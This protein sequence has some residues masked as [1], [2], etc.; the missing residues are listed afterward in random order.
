MQ[1]HGGIILCE[2]DLRSLFFL[3]LNCRFE[4]C[5]H[6]I[7]CLIHDLP[8]FHCQKT[9]KDFQ[10]VLSHTGSSPWSCVQGKG[11]LGKYY[12]QMNSLI[13]VLPMMLNQGQGHHY[14]FYTQDL[15]AAQEL[16]TK[17]FHQN[18]NKSSENAQEKS[19]I[20]NYNIHIH[21]HLYL[22]SSSLHWI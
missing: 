14:H 12:P 7:E 3:K 16:S 5:K 9:P 11:W 10:T 18:V 8:V 13:L 6:P 1:K 2:P 22:K 17:N 15:E 20:C 19:Y 4:L 21:S